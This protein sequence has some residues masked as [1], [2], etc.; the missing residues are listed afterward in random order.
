MSGAELEAARDRGLRFRVQIRGLLC[1]GE[2]TSETKTTLLIAYVDIALEHHEAV[3]LLIKSKL[4]GSA[5]ALTRP[6]FETVFR[7]LWINCASH[8]QIEKAAR[9]DNKF[10]PIGDIVATIDDRYSTDN[11][12]TSIKRKS[13]T[14]MCSYVHSGLLQTARRFT[15]NTVKSSYSNIEL[16]EVLNATNTAIILL[17]RMFF[18]SL[19]WTEQA[20]IVEKM[21]TGDHSPA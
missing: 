20:A 4:Y 16:L 6:L 15:D 10:P 3:A 8:D 18:M 12:F 17:G 13:W 21:L 5:F 9:N 19:Q 2:Y 7:A 11:F 14:A 1:E